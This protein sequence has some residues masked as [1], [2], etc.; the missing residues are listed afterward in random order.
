MLRQVVESYRFR[1]VVS[2]WGRERLEHEVLVAR[3]LASAFASGELRLQCADDRWLGGEAGQVVLRG[4]PLVGYCPLPDEP[5]MLLRADALA[6]LLALAREQQDPDY[7]L[8][9]EAF[10]RRADFLRWTAR[11]GLDAPAFWR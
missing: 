10:I 8:L 4:E 5:P 6:H 1:D 9:H 2:L 3:C 7:A 11:R